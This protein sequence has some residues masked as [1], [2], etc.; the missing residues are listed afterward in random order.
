MKKT[1]LSS[2]FAASLLLA[3]T[4]PRAYTVS[5]G[6]DPVTQDVGL[7]SMVDVA[8]RISGLGNATAPSLSMFDI[9]VSFDSARLSFSSATFG[10]PVLGDQLDIFDLGGN[11]TWAGLTGEG[12]LNLFELS[13]DLPDD[14]DDHQA[15]SFTLVTLSFNA[16]SVGSSPLELSFSSLGDAYGDPISAEVIDGN[17]TVVPN[18]AT[19]WLM[20]AA[21]FGMSGL[22]RRRKSL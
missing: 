12:N 14:L 3:A 9:D 6:F 18:P 20:G 17:V 1:I 15:A 16:L 10:D 8:L 5:L 11:S 19:I 2:I 21:L 7:G 13:M 4:T 22:M